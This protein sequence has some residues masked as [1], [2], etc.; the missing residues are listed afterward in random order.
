MASI[1]ERKDKD[2]KTRYYVQ[3]HDEIQ[4][5]YWPCCI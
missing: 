4:K 5:L 2:G 1:K 3:I